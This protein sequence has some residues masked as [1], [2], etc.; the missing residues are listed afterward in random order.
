M[1]WRRRRR[2][3]QRA[4][5]RGIRAEPHPDL[6][7]TRGADPHRYADAIA[8]EVATAILADIAPTQRAA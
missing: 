3:A 2:T 6:K 8:E 5:G 1:R 7:P 4:G